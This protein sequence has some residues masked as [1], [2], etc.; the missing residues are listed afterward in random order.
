MT[1]VADAADGGSGL[2]GSHVRWRSAPAGTT[3]W[4][5]WST[6]PFWGGGTV[7]Q[8]ITVVRGRRYCFSAQS[9]DN[10][11][12]ASSWTAERCT[13]VPL[14]DQQLTASP[15][16]TRDPSAAGSFWTSWT[17]TSTRGASLT[18]ATSLS[19][20]R[21]GV[22]ALTCATCGSIAVYVGS[23]QVASYSLASAT[24]VSRRLLLLPAFATARVGKVRVVVTSAAGRLVRIDGLAVSAY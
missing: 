5:A 18:T 10:A 12:N 9:L 23:A 3:A 24:S 20:K 6:G 2:Y 8:D 16:W 11:R 17:Q 22:V 19:V 15:G 1:L 13:T 14:D 7:R 21:L 4:S